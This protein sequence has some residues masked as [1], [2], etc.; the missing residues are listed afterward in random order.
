MDLPMPP[1]LAA[2]WR[3]ACACTLG[4]M[5]AACQSP[6]QLHADDGSTAIG[7][8]RLQHRFGSEP[9]GP[10]VEFEATGFR[11]RADQQLLAS[12]T[13]TL[14]GQSLTGP[15]LL[16]H[17]A[18]VVAAS[19]TY[20]HRLFAGR[21]AELE[22]FA[23]GTWV[24][25]DWTSTSANAA[26]PALSSRASWTGPTGGA[27]G[28]LRLAP[29]W[30]LEMRYL[31]AVD[32]GSGSADSGWRTSSELAIAWRPAEALQL[33]CG[34]AENRSLVRPEPG[35]SELSIRARGPFL[36]LLLGF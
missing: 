31:G 34:F 19:L 29:S 6:T 23:G 36:G 24:A 9:G 1:P 3:A 12:D 4:A 26:N 28:R 18:R 16:Q 32:L 33:R 5:L 25:T 2:A 20:N 17:R 13:A 35:S 11:A 15:V 21:P 22:W 30:A 10:G 8:L 27:L 7:S 14:G